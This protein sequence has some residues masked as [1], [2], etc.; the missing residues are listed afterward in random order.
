LGIISG[1]CIIGYLVKSRELRHLEDVSNSYIF[2][3]NELRQE[4][5]SLRVKNKS[6][7]NVLN[8]YEGKLEKRMYAVFLA[9]EETQTTEVVIIE[10][11]YASTKFQDKDT[12]VFFMDGNL[13]GKFTNVIYWKEIERE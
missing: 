4:I 12:V 13:V 1:L 10:A 3:C 8:E 11:N 5:E 9:I 2:D 7:K 6:L